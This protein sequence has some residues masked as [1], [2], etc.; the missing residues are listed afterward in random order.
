MWCKTKCRH[1]LCQFILDN[2]SNIRIKHKTS[3]S[4][5]CICTC[6]LRNGGHLSRGRWVKPSFVQTLKQYTDYRHCKLTIHIAKATKKSCHT[7][8][9]TIRHNEITNRY[10]DSKITDIVDKRTW[11]NLIP[12]IYYSNNM[13]TRSRY[14]PIIGCYGRQHYYCVI[15]VDCKTREVL[16]DS[17][18]VLDFLICYRYLCTEYTFFPGAPFSH[19]Y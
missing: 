8:C 17:S 14:E 18:F 10:Y 5:T 13:L 2:I 7:Y 9:N 6:C 11:G 1:H 15:Y 12:D 4:W 19:M 3:D 16:K